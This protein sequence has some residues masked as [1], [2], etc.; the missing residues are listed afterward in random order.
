MAVDA[1]ITRMTWAVR[2]ADNGIDAIARVPARFQILRCGGM[3]TPD[4]LTQRS[5]A[6]TAVA[7]LEILAIL[8][9]PDSP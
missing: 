9:E 8:V 7:A 3:V 6:L 1:Q 4:S 5:D 2:V